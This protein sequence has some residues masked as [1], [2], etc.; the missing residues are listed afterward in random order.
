MTSAALLVAYAV[1]AGSLGAAWLHEAG[2]TSRSPRLAI[3][4]WQGL[5][6][7]VLL[8]LGAAGLA[9]A[10][11]L[12]HVAEDLSRLLSLCAESLRM[13]YAAPGGTPAALLGVTLFLSLMARAS[14]C[15]VRTLRS[16]RHERRK[17]VDALDVLGHRDLL[18]GALVIEHEMPYAFCVGG[19]QHRVV[20]TTALLRTLSVE[21][22][23]AV[24]AHEHAHLRQRHHVALLVCQILVAT[25]AP[26]F[27]VLRRGM[28]DVRLYAELSADDSA[29]ARVG[30]TPLRNALAALACD[31]TPAG[32]GVLAASGIDVAARLDRLEGAPPRI[33]HLRQASVALGIA[34]I[35]AVP[36]AL[37]LAPALAMAW[38]G[39]CLLG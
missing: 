22:V 16:D 8:A 6:A 39:I 5:A 28:V 11:T 25:L 31:P 1:A 24:L 14:W 33:S 20:V 19:R 36:L 35:V 21:E 29:R 7:S 37:A 23:D 3:A 9:I 27:P 34:S 4:A 15:A 30:S 12:P 13:G 38:E 32:A 17:H 26:F 18:P 2:W 10:I